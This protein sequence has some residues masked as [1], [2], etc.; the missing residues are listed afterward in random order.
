MCGDGREVGVRVHEIEGH[1]GLGKKFG[2]VINGERW[3]SRC[4]DAEKIPLEGLDTAFRGV[5]SF[6]VG[7]DGVKD[8]VLGRGEIKESSRSF[9]VEDLNFE[10]MADLTG[11]R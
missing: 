4:E 10:M 7:W 6:L 3:M 11:K 1:F 9:V 2:P 8:D 5:R